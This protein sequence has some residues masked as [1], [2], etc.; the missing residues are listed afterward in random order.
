[1]KVAN[2]H[3]SLGDS[4]QTFAEMKYDIKIFKY[5]IIKLAT[6]YITLY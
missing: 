5:K 4:W 1:M 3:L 6:M 2:Y